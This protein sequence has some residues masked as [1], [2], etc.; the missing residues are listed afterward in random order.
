M[1][2]AIHPQQVS[3]CD[4][5]CR[6]VRDQKMC[7]FLCAYVYARKRIRILTHI[8]TCIHTYLNEY[9]P[10]SIHP[11]I[12]IHTYIHTYIHTHIH[13]CLP[14]YIARFASC[15]LNL[16]NPRDEEIDDYAIPTNT[17][18]H[19]HTTCTH[20]DVHTHPRDACVMIL[21]VQILSTFSKA[22]FERIYM[23]R[24]CPS[25]GDGKPNHCAAYS[26]APDPRE[27]LS[28]N[29]I[30]FPRNMEIGVIDFQFMSTVQNRFRQ[31]LV[32]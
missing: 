11:S 20:T 22:N 2:C 14:A 13:I 24:P 5:P 17:T 27:T 28:L 10:T 26:A 15:I 1:H 12:P 21:T 3:G 7:A 23:S 32:P 31:R 4:A 30:D 25:H 29:L 16:A 19:N 9:T 6:G 18:D 8:H